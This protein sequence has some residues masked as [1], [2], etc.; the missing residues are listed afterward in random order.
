MLD[1]TIF[2]AENDLDKGILQVKEQFQKILNDVLSEFSNKNKLEYSEA[3]L[4]KLKKAIDDAFSKTKY[5][6]VVDKYLSI[7]DTILNDNIDFYN[8][9]KLSVENYL[10][11][12]KY[13]TELKNQA[14][15]NLKSSGTIYQEITKPV[16]QVMRLSIIRGISY[17]DAK[18]QLS[19]NLGKL[20]SYVKTITKDTLNT[21][22]GAINN[23]IK[24]RYKLETMIYV[25]SLIET[26]RPICLHL[27]EKS[28]WTKDELKNV[29]DEY[30]PNGVP[31]EKTIMVQ[32][33]DKEV[34]MKKGSGMIEGTDVDNFTINRGGYGCRH[35]VR[36]VK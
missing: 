32:Q 1:K 36:W 34:R 22:D 15:E 4:L 21:Y 23:E 28:R 13:L 11:K 8:K 19:G 7:F 31:S 29:L 25:G 10:I 5:E 3:Q 30:C 2:D 26:S 24:E 12:N 35:L 20:E 6:N 18:D 17:Q 33:G 9:N 27:K 14:I 16:E